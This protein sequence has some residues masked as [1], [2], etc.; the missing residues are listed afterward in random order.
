MDSGEFN[1]QWGYSTISVYK[2]NYFKYNIFSRI[3]FID[4]EFDVGN[5]IIMSICLLMC[6]ISEQILFWDDY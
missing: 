6:E 4:K 1:P 5:Y 2:N 3:Y